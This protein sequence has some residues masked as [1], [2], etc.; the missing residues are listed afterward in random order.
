M[1][2][3]S[4][5]TALIVIDVQ[6]GF[7]DLR[8]GPRNN[9]DAELK[10]KQLISLWRSTKRPIVFIRHASKSIDSPL[11]PSKPTS[12]IKEEVAPIMGET[13]ISKSVHS[14][15]IGTD[16]EA[17]LRSLDIKNIVIVGLTTDHCVST[18]TR[19]GHDLGF[20]VTIVSDATATFDRKGPD[21]KVHSAEQVHAM[22]LVNLHDE[23]AMVL[24]SNTVMELCH[25][26]KAALP[27][28]MAVHDDT[29]IAKRKGRSDGFERRMSF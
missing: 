12:E 15:F 19:M 7:D 13:V 8:W 21:G 28:K 23:F 26:D 22:T 16:L 24:D 11:H 29:V 17:H 3:F 2:Y 18:T 20:D 5:K 9:P 10:I 1:P 25:F 14:A 27:F 4:T 6:K